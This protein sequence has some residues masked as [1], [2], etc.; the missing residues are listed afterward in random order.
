METEPATEPLI[1]DKLR[2]AFEKR[3][4]ELLEPEENLVYAIP[5]LTM[6]VWVYLL[7]VTIIGA[8]AI[9]PYAIQ[10]ASTAVV[11][12]SHVYVFKTSWL[13]RAKR[14][15]IKAPLGTVESSVGGSAFPGR[16]LLIGDEKIWL[17]FPS[18]IRRRAEAMS[19]AASTGPE[20]LP[21]GDVAAAAAA[22]EAT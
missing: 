21:A 14:P 19:E 10:K 20:A 17:P 6:P 3:V 12:Q 8:L 7:S 9:L 11:T 13:G 5:N 18:R 16:Y 15:L 22:P 2:T 1:S 4:G